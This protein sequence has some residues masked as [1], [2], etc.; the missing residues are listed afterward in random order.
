MK[1][2]KFVLKKE[3]KHK[4]KTEL[5]E[6]DFGYQPFFLFVWWELA[7]GN[8]GKTYNYGISWFSV[9][10]YKIEDLEK[11]WNKI[12]KKYKTYFIT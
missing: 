6:K 4:M 3:K 12:Y 11:A 2:L 9:Q 8:K 5:V 1:I 10:A 7:K